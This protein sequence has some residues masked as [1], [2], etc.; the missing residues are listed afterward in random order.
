MFDSPFS[1]S[2]PQIDA[3]ADVIIVAD[4]FLDDYVGG[5][6][7]TTEALIES[8][9]DIK[10]QKFKASNLSMSILKSGQDKHWVFT[11]FSSMNFSLIP[12]IIGNLSY[13]VIE[14]DYKFCKYRSIEKHQELEGNPCDC[15]DDI[16]GKMISALFHGAKSLWFMSEAQEKDTWRDFRFSEKMIVSC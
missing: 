13:S 11:N 2:A 16:H 12:T 10:I 5:A 8:A 9:S 3:D 7:L 14:Y 15:H 4:Y 1:T 6:E